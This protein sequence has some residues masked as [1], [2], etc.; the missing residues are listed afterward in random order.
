M[1]TIAYK[2]LCG[3]APVS[4]P[5]ALTDRGVAGADGASDEVGEE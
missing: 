4:G 1:P 2:R 3:G 5:G